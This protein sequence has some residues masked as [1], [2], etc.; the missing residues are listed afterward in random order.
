MYVQELFKQIKNSIPVELFLHDLWISNTFWT[1]IHWSWAYWWITFFPQ[2]KCVWKTDTMIDS[3][4]VAFKVWLLNNRIITSIK[5]LLQWVSWH[6]LVCC[7]RNKYVQVTIHTLSKISYIKSSNGCDLF[8]AGMMRWV[9]S[10]WS[11]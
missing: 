6:N 3:C 9:F 10:S 8:I 7:S 2:R 4:T 11:W 1:H 5:V